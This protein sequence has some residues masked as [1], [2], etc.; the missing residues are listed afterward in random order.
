MGRMHDIRIATIEIFYAA[1]VSDGDYKRT[2]EAYWGMSPA[3][4]PVSKKLADQVE[5]FVD[6]ILNHMEEIDTTIRSA[7]DNWDLTRIAKVDLG[8]LR[9]A[10]Y[11]VLFRRQTPVRVIIDEAV[12]IAKEYSTSKSSAFVN[13]V[14]DR[15]VRESRKEEMKIKQE[16]KDNGRDNERTS[17]T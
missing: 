10:A 7:S 9:L 17:K 6:G 2:F 11:E 8:I 1:D 15:M 16:A 3:P 4:V 14:L 13:G 12:E 5:I